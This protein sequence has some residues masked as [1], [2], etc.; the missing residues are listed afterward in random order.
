MLL[1]IVFDLDV[2]LTA[3][4][5]NVNPSSGI[6]NLLN[7]CP[8]KAKK[9]RLITIKPTIKHKSAK[10]TGDIPPNPIA[11]RSDDE[12]KLDTFDCGDGSTALTVL[13]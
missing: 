11:A 7:F 2:V 13:V 9:S 6:L 3:A 1:A 12:F 10:T 5:V 8:L 4:P